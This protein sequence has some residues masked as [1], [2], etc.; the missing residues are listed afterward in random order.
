MG[1]LLQNYKQLEYK[2]FRIYLKHVKR[3]VAGIGFLKMLKMAVCGIKCIDLTTE[4]KIMS[5]VHFS[6]NQKLQ[7]QK[8]S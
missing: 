4:T 7:I 2:I 3:Q 5:D 1:K 8:T 6:Y